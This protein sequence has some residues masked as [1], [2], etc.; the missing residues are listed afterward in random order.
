MSAEARTPVEIL[1][2]HV[3]LDAITLVAHERTPFTENALKE[4]KIDAI[5]AQ[6][7]GHAVRSAL[8]TL[9]AR[10]DNR[11]LVAEQETIRIE[12]LLKD[13]L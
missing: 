12:V 3:D 1:S 10:S 8:R 11:E 13:N 5:V 7:A 2:K 4:F 6:N 9:R